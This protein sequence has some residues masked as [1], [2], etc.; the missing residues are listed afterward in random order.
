MGLN[1]A[2]TLS[3][4]SDSKPSPGVLSC[5]QFPQQGLYDM[6]A[7][8]KQRVCVC[9]QPCALFSF[10]LHLVTTIIIRV[11]TDALVVECLLCL[12]LK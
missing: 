5:S 3:P 8:E 2:H 10:F 1:S 7:T 12:A 6:V 9:R 4:L 11:I